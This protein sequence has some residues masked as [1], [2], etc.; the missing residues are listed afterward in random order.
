[1]NY[2]AAIAL[3]SD[4]VFAVSCVYVL[5]GQE[6]VFKTVLDDIEVDDLL[7]VP[8]TKGV[9]F[10]V[11]QVKNL[12]VDFEFS[13][14]SINYVWALSKLDLVGHE[15]LL[16]NEKAAVDLLREADRKKR[17]KDVRETMVT[18]TS[19]ELDAIKFLPEKTK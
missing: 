12:A 4:K 17:R 11:V 1:M 5:G 10:S 19:T 9:G 3:V 18:L 13:S 7:V 8:S 15:I 2:S 14:S 16:T 6:Y